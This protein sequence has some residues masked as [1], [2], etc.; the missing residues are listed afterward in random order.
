MANI[1]A[2][3]AKQMLDWVLGGAAATQP[4]SRLAALTF[5]VPTSVSALGEIQT[6]SGYTR[7]SVGF[8]AAA[9]P[10]GSV[11]NTASFSFGPFS[12]SQSVLGM[13][14]YDTPG[15]NSG[16]IWWYGTLLTAR[17]VLPGDTLVVN[18]GALLI[19]LS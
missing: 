16:N 17:T 15:L 10:Q 8:G 7:A 14:I 9:S 1:G 18:S 11:S 5:G 6:N 19:T 3:A 12:S 2:F 4:T 13:L